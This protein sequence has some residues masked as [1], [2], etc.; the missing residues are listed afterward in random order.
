MQD[1]GPTELEY[2]INTSI[3]VTLNFFNDTLPNI[4]ASC[5]A[6]GIFLCIFSSNR[7]FSILNWNVRKS[8]LT[9]FSAREGID[10]LENWSNID[11]LLVLHPIVMG[12]VHK[13]GQLV[14]TKLID[15]KKV[16][17]FSKKNV[18]AYFFC[19]CLQGTIQMH[20]HSTIMSKMVC[21]ALEGLPDI[22]VN[23]L[24]QA[25]LALLDQMIGRW[26]NVEWQRI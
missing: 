18:K 11:P 3:G 12:L 20:A 26:M 22:Q 25:Q 8:I 21:N 5:Y 15:R 2:K 9:V 24:Q 10:L 23:N 16:F 4:F 13:F 1:M 17:F 14:R 19:F 7:R 6:F